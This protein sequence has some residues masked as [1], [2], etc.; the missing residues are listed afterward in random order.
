MGRL[1]TVNVDNISVGGKGDV[2]TGTQVK[3]SDSE[4]E[5]LLAAGRFDDGTLTDNGE[6]TYGTELEAIEQ[7]VTTLETTPSPAVL[8]ALTTYAPGA[9]LD[10][11]ERFTN[12]TTTN[13]NYQSVAETAQIAGLELNF[14][15]TGRMVEVTFHAPAVRSSVSN[16]GVGVYLIG[17]KGGEALNTASPFTRVALISSPGTT[18]TYNRSISASWDLPTEEGVEY[19]LRVG[20]YQGAAGTATFET[21]ADYPITLKARNH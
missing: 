1:I 14:T 13:T 8:E 2:D 4:Y 6:I 9:V 5:A 3:I 19:A 10:Y 21:F 20:C 15:G 11:A 16:N 12:F 7:R 18:S 17:S